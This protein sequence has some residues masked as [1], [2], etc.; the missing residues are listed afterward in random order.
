MATTKVKHF[1]SVAET[2]AVSK[3]ASD[4][5]EDHD[6]D[7]VSVCPHL[8]HPP[9]PPSL[10]PTHL[11]HSFHS[12][13]RFDNDIDMRMRCSVCALTLSRTLSLLTSRNACGGS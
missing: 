2:A 7:D 4:V 11:T 8:P 9:F 13:T 10:P 5:L 12:L 6:W 1:D 3:I